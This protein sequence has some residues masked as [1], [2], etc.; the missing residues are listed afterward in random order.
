MKITP[1]IRVS[2]KST[3]TYIDLGKVLKSLLAPA[4]KKRRR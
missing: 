3:R 4:P 2:T 1:M